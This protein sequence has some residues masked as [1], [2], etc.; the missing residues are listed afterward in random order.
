MRLALEVLIIGM[1]C[2]GVARAAPGRPAG[3][4]DPR[5]IVA[6][7]EKLRSIDWSEVTPTRVQEIWTPP[8]RG[9]ECTEQACS[10]MVREGRII[11]GEIECAD[12]F[13]FDTE[14]PHD[15][16]V[17]Q[18]LHSVTIHYT[19][20]RRPEIVSIAKSF[21]AAVGLPAA[22]TKDI[23]ASDVQP[24]QWKRAGPA[25]GTSVLDLRLTRIGAGWSLFFDY[26]QRSGDSAGRH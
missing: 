17:R 3:C 26:L 9:L 11:N 13:A 6:S 25:E 5:V 12:V 23:G 8:I 10:S 20:A 21:A 16:P 14:S 7:L 2:G 4:T 24:F 18:Y 22:Q 15:G 1:I 19:A